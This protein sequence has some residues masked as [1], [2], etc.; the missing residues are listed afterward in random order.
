MERDSWATRLG[1]ILAAVGSAVGLGN[2]WRFP[3]VVSEG[4]GAALV[5][6]YLAIV[7]LVGLPLMTAEFAIG[8]LSQ[9]SPL[10]AVRRLGGPRW[11]PLG[12]LFV[13]CGFGILSYYAVIAGWTMR[14]AFDAVRNAIPADTA[15]YFGEVS[16]GTSSVVCHV[17][18]MA[19]TIW[20]V[21]QGVRK[22][23]ER[24]VLVMMPI[25]FLLLLGLAI[26]ASTMEGGSAGYAYYLKP[27]L[28]A[29]GRPG[30]LAEAAGQ[31]FFSLSLGMGALMTYASYLRSK[32][33][34]G[35]EATTVALTDFGV[36]F[37]A[38]LV[39][40]PVIAAFALRDEVGESAVG[41][42]FIALPKA[43][44]GLGMVGSI[45][46]TAFFVLLF[47]AALSSSISLLEVVVTA[48]IDRWGWRRG[49]AAV[50]VGGIVTLL[51]VPS[52]FNLDFLDAMD[53][54]LGNFLLLVG[55]LGISLLVGWR[56][57]DRADAELA[58]GL[59]SPGLRKGWGV[60]LRFVAPVIL[61]A[62]LLSSLPATWES[63][64]GLLGLS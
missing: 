64:Q 35:R 50:L 14:Y 29:M 20:I 39:V 33:N 27:N 56:L 49:R 25:L 16:A 23:L 24:S 62:V 8:R 7:A 46:D 51:G 40:F 59:S 34:L 38:G 5:V 53:K 45:V 22:G 6:L 31:A 60:L 61:V 42:L 4:G 63:I 57:F 32:E 30:I 55:G 2:M 37:V 43:F 58:Q 26:W 1:F 9:E 10:V 44:E 15:A 13:A 54:L 28:E 19:V 48:T 47:V 52:A 41:A 36:A 12:W 11:A 21:V 17:L 3:Y 18:F